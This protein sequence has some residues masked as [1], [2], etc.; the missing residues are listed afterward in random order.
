MTATPPPA[1][2]GALQLL[3]S[4][5]L[6]WFLDL[7]PD[8]VASGPRSRPFCRTIDVVCLLA[9]AHAALRGQH[10]QSD[11]LQPCCPDSSE[12]SLATGSGSRCFFS[13]IALRRSPKAGALTAGDFFE[14]P[15]LACDN[16]VAQASP[17]TS[18][19]T[20]I[21]GRHALS[22]RSRTA[23]GRRPESFL[24]GG[25]DVGHPARRSSARHW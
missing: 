20:M 14:A 7:R 24:L 18:S 13:S 11:V 6:R 4:Y 9:I 15:P 21:S 22:H 2:P 16:K 8:L 19:A 10:V 12:I 17:S 25:E 1:G 3:A 23:A 5:N